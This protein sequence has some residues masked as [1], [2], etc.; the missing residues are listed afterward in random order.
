[1]KTVTATYEAEEIATENKP[2]EL[3][4]VFTETG[5]DIALYTDASVA[6]VYNGNTYLPAAIKRSALEF[7]SSIGVS[8]MKVQFAWSDDSVVNFVSQNPVE[9]TWVEVLRTY[10]DLSPPEVN[11]VFIGQ[12]K[13]VSFQGLQAEA[14]CV[15]LEYYL[16]VG[17]PNKCYQRLC[18]HFLY[19][20]GCGVLTATYRIPAV[21]TGF[22]ATSNIVYCSA[23]TPQVANYF[24]N[25]YIEARG[26]TRMIVGYEAN[27]DHF[28]LIYPI[29]TLIVGDAINMLPG[30]DRTGKTC[31]EKFNNMINF[32]GFEYIPFDN[33][34][35]WTA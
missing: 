12:I 27:A 2:A 16:N 30:C 14:E 35:L 24:T 1:V 6:I 20:T 17:I 19:S 13:L 9:V 5:G 4:R 31:L 7:D 21:V 15:S 25:G 34:T 33:P 3:Y 22:G 8:K 11:V 26:T 28:S 18:N 10:L 23:M 32:F 29:P